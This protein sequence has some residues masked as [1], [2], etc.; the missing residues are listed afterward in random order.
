VAVGK[1]PQDNLDILYDDA[2]S[3]NLSTEEFDN[4]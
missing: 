1:L 3:A 4:F 2:N